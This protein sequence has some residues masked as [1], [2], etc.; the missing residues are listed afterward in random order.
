VFLTGGFGQSEYLFSQV[1]QFTRLWRI[2]VKRPKDGW[3]AV[4]RG[5]VRKGLEKG[6]GNVTYVRR[7]R[8]HYGISVSQPFSSFQHSED[9]AYIDPFDGKRKARGQMTW[10]LKKNDALLS[11]QPNHASIDL[12][13]RFSPGDNKMFETRLVVLNDDAPP[14]RY[15]D[16]PSGSGRVSVASL[17]YDF[18][19]I[20]QSRFQAFPAGGNGQPYLCAYFKLEICLENN[21][22][23][24]MSFDGQKKEA[25][26]M[27]GIE[28]VGAEE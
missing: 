17:K 1:E 15:A 13:R 5:A 14:Q 2:R 9:D 26:T 16:L 19:A 8:R 25:V 6:R 28:F 22:E 12:C 21:L 11:N 23:F 10:L 4:V 7:C 27:S 3:S 24:W 20:P 18:S